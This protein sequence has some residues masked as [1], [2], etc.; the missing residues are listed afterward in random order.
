MISLKSLAFLVMFIFPQNMQNLVFH[1]GFPPSLCKWSMETKLQ[2]CYVS[3]ELINIWQQTFTY[4]YIFRTPLR[5]VI[6]GD[7]NYTNDFSGIH[8]ISKE[9]N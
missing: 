2:N 7:I 3:H 8:M 9:V 6:K 4:D 5:M 1:D